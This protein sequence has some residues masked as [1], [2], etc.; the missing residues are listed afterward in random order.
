M[1]KLGKI[2][3]LCVFVGLAALSGAS[4]TNAQSVVPTQVTP[5][6]S[7]GTL[8]YN[9]YGGGHENVNLAT[10]NLNLE[11][12]LV[13]LPGR[14]GHNLTVGVEFDSNIQE[15]EATFDNVLGV[16]D[17]SFGVEY[18]PAPLSNT[19]YVGG[20]WRYTIPALQATATQLG[21][22]PKAP[23]A[24]CY[25]G[26]IVTLADG[27]KHQFG[28]KAHCFQ[29]INGETILLTSDDLPTMSLS[30]DSAACCWIP[31][32]KTILCC[33]SKTVR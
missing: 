20:S 15:L 8:A 22:N 33:I 16:Y 9:T 5:Q 26:F 1:L 32:T 11:I 4:R 29:N 3:L 13:T 31:Q 23:P 27:S 7:T 2:S 21:V 18:R 30:L 10:G 25:E 19:T 28:N 14:K 24:Y 6:D 12:P 17:Y